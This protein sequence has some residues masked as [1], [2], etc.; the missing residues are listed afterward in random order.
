MA[1]YIATDLTSW[2]PMP[3][4]ASSL[5]HLRDIDIEG[6]VYRQCTPTYYA[7]LRRQMEKARVAHDQQRLDA[8]AYRA[9]ADRFNGIHQQAVTQYGAQALQEAYRTFDARTYHP[10]TQGTP[11]PRQSS[12]IQSESNG[13]LMDQQAL[14]GFVIELTESVA[15]Q[16][17]LAPK[18]ASI[19]ASVA[20]GLRVKGIGN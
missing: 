3:E 13:R 5:T 11:I 7:Y 1:L 9:L 4:Q 15:P 20:P 18:A 14:A 12:P 19:P 10:P 6:R 2:Q 8:T 17:S 16:P